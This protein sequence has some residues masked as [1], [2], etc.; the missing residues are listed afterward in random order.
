MR[1]AATALA[2]ALVVAACGER[3]PA[4]STAPE[5]ATATFSTD[6]SPASDSTSTGTV[7]PAGSDTA[8]LADY[9]TELADGAAGASTCDELHHLSL[10]GVRALAEIAGDGPAIPGYDQAS[11]SD[12]MHAGG[13]GMSL[14][15]P[16][17]A[18]PYARWGNAI[19]VLDTH[20]AVAG[21]TDLGES[22][23]PDPETE[24]A[25]EAYQEQVVAE[26]VGGDPISTRYVELGCTAD[27]EAIAV[28]AHL[29]L[30]TTGVERDLAALTAISDLIDAADPDDD[31]LLVTILDV[32]E[33]LEFS[34]LQRLLHGPPLDGDD[35]AIR[36]VLDEVVAA[37]ETAAGDDPA[38]G[39]LPLPGLPTALQEAS[40]AAAH[41]GGVC[42]SLRLRGRV[43]ITSLDD[44]RVVVID[45]PP[46]LPD[47]DT[48]DPFEGVE[49]P[50]ACSG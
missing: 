30:P 8:A 43:A 24:A 47:P 37:A 41:D 7:G 16:D 29:G 11:A 39:D 5:G 20:V 26:G 9:R 22:E 32:G 27:D 35:V 14:V 49:L 34:I 38:D 36:G 21:Y 4:V 31:T 45:Q 33:R 12:L 17:P 48:P 42:L 23:Q 6:A 13:L 19:T 25:I 1:T 3:G 15:A 46:M 44:D 2:L 10:D 18:L 50:A 40:R 28:A